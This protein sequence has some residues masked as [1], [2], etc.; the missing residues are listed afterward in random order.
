MLSTLGRSQIT[1]QKVLKAQV[2]GG[3][4]P[5]TFT[6][7]ARYTT[8]TS[9]KSMLNTGHNINVGARQMRSTLFSRSSSSSIINV[10]TPFNVIGR[11]SNSNM[12]R[13]YT[14]TSSSSS[15]QEQESQKQEQKQEQEEEVVEDIG[16]KR[17]GRWL[18]FSAGLVGVMVVVGGI[19][20]LTES[21]LSMVEWK[22]IV[23]AIPPLTQQQWEEEFDRYKQY[24]EYQKLNKGMTLN[25]FKQIFFWEYSHRLMGR[26]IGVAFF[27]PFV[28]YLRKGYID[29]TLAKKLT[30]IF[31]LGG[32]QGALGWYMVKSGLDEKLI[33]GEVPRVSQYRLAAHLGSAFVI[34]SSLLWYGLDLVSPRLSQ[35][36]KAG[37]KPNA[38]TLSVLR[39][40]SPVAGMI[41]LTAMSGAFVAG[42]DAGLIY[43]TFPLMGGQWVPEDLINPRIQPAYKNMFEHDVTVQFQ[44]RVLATL[45]YASILGLTQLARR[46]RGGLTPRARLAAN[47]LAVMGTA[48][49]ILGIS[50]LLTFVPVSLGASHQAGSLTLLSIAI[51]LLHELKKLPK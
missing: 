12:S 41:F 17:V 51:W 23:G 46:G 5:L 13:S 35:A 9:S 4:H 18:L 50:T 1:L 48:Q 10:D 32:A 11:N 22:P 7:M 45:T 49:V 34:Y 20:R 29:R 30:A 28:Y 38:A 15:T 40:A 24:P 37:L 21:G 33:V 8:I 31:L 25:E 3:L 44:H 47:S 42:L 16:R 26:M 36:V 43:N 39:Y 6:P 14:S 19:T 2:G 27:F